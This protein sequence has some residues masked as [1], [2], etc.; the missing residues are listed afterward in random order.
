MLVNRAIKVIHC[1][2]PI[3]L[4]SSLKANFYTERR[5]PGRVKF[6]DHLKTKSG[7]QTPGN[8]SNDAGFD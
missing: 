7:R 4:V 2:F 8:C 3:R 6:F 1:G 5:R